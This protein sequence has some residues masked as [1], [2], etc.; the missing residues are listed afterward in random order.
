MSGSADSLTFANFQAAIED[1]YYYTHDGLFKTDYDLLMQE[2]RSLEGKDALL[3]A[4]YQEKVLEPFVVYLSKKL[5]KNNFDRI[6]G[7]DEATLTNSDRNTKKTIVK[8]TEALL[9]RKHEFTSHRSAFEDLRAFQSL[10]TSLFIGVYAKDFFAKV[11]P[12]LAPLVKWG[13]RSQP[14]THTL[15]PGKKG[16]LERLGIQAGIVNLPFEHKNGGLLAWSSIVHEIAG[17]HFLKSQEKIVPTLETAVE[18]AIEAAIEGQ[19]WKLTPEESAKVKVYWKVC[20][21]EAAADVIG[22]LCMGPAFLLGLIGYYRGR[23]SD[24]KISRSG[25]LHTEKSFNGIKFFT[26]EGYQINYLEQLS[27]AI[28]IGSKGIFGYQDAQ[29]KVPIL[30]EKHTFPGNKHPILV[31]RVAMLIQVLRSWGKGYS[32][33]VLIFQGFLDEDLGNNSIVFKEFNEVSK[34]LHD[35][36]IDRSALL[37]SARFVA[38]AILEAPLERMGS[39]E[40]G[41]SAAG[42]VGNELQAQGIGEIFHWS[43]E[44]EALV[45]SIRQDVFQDLNPDK[46]LPLKYFLRDPPAQH[47]HIV[48]AAVLECSHNTEISLEA[49]FVKMK[50]LL[51]LTNIPTEG[52]LK[53]EG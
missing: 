5:K 3:E 44:D 28:Q 52:T 30:Y 4:T 13:E 27:S 7:A 50:K 14:Y 18:A 6:F 21:E 16:S 25:P 22:L 32:N 41:E 36:E 45:N 23:S 35:V 19:D 38:N 31:L 9:Q 11:D 29:K 53:K 40:T 1:V 47:R 10:V 17:H 48:A 39:S 51:R 37:A 15:N 8:V 43:T 12:P 46:T 33:W 42:V 24:G 26:Q 34:S 49:I 20:T 2:L